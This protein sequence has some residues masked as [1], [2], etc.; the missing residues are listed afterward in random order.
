M[1]LSYEEAASKLLKD[2][3]YRRLMADSYLNFS[4]AEAALRYRESEEFAE[5]RRILSEKKPSG[6]VLDLGAGNGILSFALAKEGYQVL[7]LEPEDG[8]VTGRL[9]IKTVQ[10]A[11]GTTF[12][13]LNGWGEEIP[14]QDAAAGAVIAR[15][16]LHHA[17][18]LR[19]MC[20]EVYRVLKPGGF[21]LALREHVL[22]KEEDR[23]LFLASHPMHRL[24]EGENAYTPRFYKE[25]IRAAGFS[26]LKVYAFWDSVL[27]YAPI[28]RDGLDAFFAEKLSR[29]VPLLPPFFWKNCVLK[30]PGASRLLR[31][32]LNAV[33]KTPGSLYS[34]EATKR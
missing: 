28:R 1:P 11:T 23:E 4:P 10:S 16:V 27:N 26:G 19:K 22:F 17:R 24:T 3:R 21:F 6:P 12:E 15:Q 5:I 25:S 14:L 34:F 30:I 32:L 29:R 9:A 31:Q 8:A 7:A 13:I 18:D 20:S 2:E 33:N